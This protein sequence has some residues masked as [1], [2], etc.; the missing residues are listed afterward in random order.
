MTFVI[1]TF[2]TKTSSQ[3]SNSSWPIFNL[4]RFASK[5]SG[6]SSTNGRK[7]YGKHLGLKKDPNS[8]VS[9]GN[10]IM[11]QRGFKFWPGEGVVAGRDHTLVASKVGRVLIHYDLET[12]RRY[13][14]VNDGTMAP[15]IYPTRGI[16]KKDLE[17]R[18]DAVK[19]LSLDQKGR[20]DYVQALMSEMKGEYEKSKENYLRKRVSERD[21]RKFPL[22]DLTLV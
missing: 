18:V 6:G 3:L 13:I 1:P 20:Y 15:E 4:I 7:A 14:S 9:I 21:H 22:V 8:E 5:K 16:F 10:I 12:Q 19:Y 2:L 17:E 11:R